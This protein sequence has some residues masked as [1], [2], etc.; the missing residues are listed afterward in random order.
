MTVLI[1]SLRAEQ[2]DWIGTSL[3]GMIGILMAGLSNSPINRLVVNDIGPDLPLQA[4]LRIGKYVRDAPDSFPTTEAAQAYFRNVLSPFGKLEDWQW[5][6]LSDHSIR[7]NGQGGYRLH[8]DRRLTLFNIMPYTAASY[9][10]LGSASNAPY[11][12]SAERTQICS[13]RKL[14]AR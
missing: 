4:V 6:H 12:S 7:P 13:C 14:R 1:A 10:Q 2:V 8:Y 11:S 9:G 3:G 5:R